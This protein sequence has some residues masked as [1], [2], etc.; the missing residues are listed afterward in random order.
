MVFNNAVRRII[1]LERGYSPKVYDSTFIELKQDHYEVK[2]KGC[3]IIADNH[4]L[5]GGSKYKNVLWYCNY[6]D[7]SEEEEN[8]TIMKE[9]V[10]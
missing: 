7:P 5:S 1:C 4:F 3:H 9:L 10:L 2:F 8:R 6:K